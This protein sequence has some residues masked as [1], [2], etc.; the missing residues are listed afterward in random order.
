MLYRNNYS[1][2]ITGSKEEN[3]IIK[4]ELGY[5]IPNT[6][7]LMGKFQL[8]ELIKFISC[9]DVLVAASTGPLHIAAALG[10]HAVG[11]YPPIKPMHPDRWK[12]I[13]VNVDVLCV[14][15]DCEVCRRTNK[16]LCMQ[17]I[18][19]EQVLDVILKTSERTGTML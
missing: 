8:E 4:K 1:V 2:F 13:G 19:P 3:E 14:N 10:I 6:Y 5:E 18:T 16:C 12:P 11:I 17:Q 9:C 15:K 7:N